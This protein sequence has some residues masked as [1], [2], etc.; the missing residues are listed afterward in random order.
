MEDKNFLKIKT[1]KTQKGKTYLKNIL[2]KLIEDPKQ[3]LFI[4]TTK[5]N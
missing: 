2:P 1:A 4:N 5:S 3:C